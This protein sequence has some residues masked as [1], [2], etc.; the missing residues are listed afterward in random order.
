MGFD[1]DAETYLW[2]VPDDDDDDTSRADAE[3]YE[4]LTTLAAGGMGQVWR[5][6]DRSSGA[7]LAMKVAMAP[8]RD[9]NV[10][11]EREYEALS[12]LNHKNIVVVH[13]T[14]TWVDGRA[15]FTME[16]VQGPTLEAELAGCSTLAERLALL[17][18]VCDACRAVGHA[19][20][21]RIVH[22]D[23]KPANLM[24]D[25]SGAW[26]L[27]RLGRLVVIDWGLTFDPSVP[28]ATIP[29]Q[30]LG[31]ACY[32]PP[33][34]A[35]ARRDLQNLPADVWALGAIL[36]EVVTG[37]PPFQGL[38][39]RAVVRMT[40]VTPPPRVSDIR[41]IDPSLARI[42]DRALQFDPSDR[43]P[44]ADALAAALDAWLKG[45]RVEP[46]RVGRWLRALGV[47]AG[48]AVMTVIASVSAAFTA[49]MVQPGPSPIPLS[50]PPLP[51]LEPPVMPAVRA[52]ARE[53]L[54]PVPLATRPVVLPPAPPPEVR[55]SV[56]QAEGGWGEVALD[57]VPIGQ[58]PFRD[59]AVPGDARQ[60]VVD[61]SV[62][63]HVTCDL[64]L[65]GVE[66]LTVRLG[67][68][69]ATLEPPVGRCW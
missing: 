10:R 64:S 42:V 23:L 34:Q 7:T 51:R 60:L 48:F 3:R 1:S 15:Y 41:G 44:S 18:Y 47:L 32:M 59:R 46:A 40:R 16:H 25:R 22:R 6:L 68:D 5:V 33:E 67:R 9:F 38:S 57:G 56:V 29:G 26:A 65:D 17:P 62:L 8:T 27:T 19:H 30:I 31:P 69:R 61:H 54:P 63:G 66:A 11:I 36:Y 2:L 4:V 39:A 37:R 28:G 24:I 49:W 52:P 58:L 35:S 50:A 43:Y 12:R 45:N 13:E 53:A 55:L 21:N 14:G 20:R